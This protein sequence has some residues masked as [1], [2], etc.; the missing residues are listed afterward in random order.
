MKNQTLR[1][2][3]AGLVL[4]S[5]LVAVPVLADTNTNGSWG[6]DDGKTVVDYTVTSNYTVVIPGTL[7]APTNG[8]Y[9]G[10][11]NNVFINSNSTIEDGK[12]I[13]V[14]LGASQTFEATLGMTSTIPFT[15]QYT[16]K[17][18]ATTGTPTPIT[19]VGGTATTVLEQTS[20]QIAAV[21]SEDALD[22]TTGS[23][24]LSAH[25]EAAVTAAQAEKADVA[26]THTGT[27]TF[28]VALNN[29]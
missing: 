4:T 11:A 12:K 6:T 29:T 3:L 16:S 27:V 10:A 5:A 25:V 15:V 14:A 13:T 1:K 21:T 17:I 23:D 22:A 9:T 19:S 18:G 7:T 24:A 2:S 28:T 8:T 26:G 20:A